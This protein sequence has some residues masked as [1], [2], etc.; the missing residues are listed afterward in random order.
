MSKII[1]IVFLIVMFSV[2]TFGQKAETKP[3][4][5]QFG[6]CRPTLTEIGRQSSFHFTYRYKITT[7]ENGNVKDLK[8]ISDLNN[9]RSMVNVENVIPC[10]Q[11]WKLNSLKKFTVTIAIGTKNIVNSLRIRSK[12]TEIKILL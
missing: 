11:K 8:T 2:T 6:V 10:I 9:Y 12:S 7:D 3:E 1:L 5:L 4:E